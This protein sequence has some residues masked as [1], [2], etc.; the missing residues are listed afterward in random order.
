[1]LSYLTGPYLGKRGS[2]PRRVCVRPPR[3]SRLWRRAV[4]RRRDHRCVLPA[5][6]ASSPPAWLRLQTSGSGR[7]RL[8]AWSR[9]AL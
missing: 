6:Q 7:G 2:G 5:L 1:M 3:V 9:P 4:R 8:Q